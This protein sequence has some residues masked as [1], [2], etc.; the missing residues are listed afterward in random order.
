[1]P[2]RAIKMENARLCSVGQTFVLSVKKLSCHR[3]AVVTTVFCPQFP[4]FLVGVE[5]EV[6]QH[7]PFSDR[8]PMSFDP[9][10]VAS[11]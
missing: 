6:V 7:F 4:E 8:D 10:G 5:W 2:T 9:F 11:L 3:E 1:M